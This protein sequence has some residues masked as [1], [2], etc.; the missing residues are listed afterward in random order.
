MAPSAWNWTVPLTAPVQELATAAASLVDCPNTVGLTV[1]VTVVVDVAAVTFWTSG[2]PL[3][4][5]SV[6]P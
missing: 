5:T 6:P 3:L 1:E 2:P 4:G